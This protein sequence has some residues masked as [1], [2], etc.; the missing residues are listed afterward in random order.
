VCEK[1]ERQ[2]QLVQRGC[3]GRSRFAAP[4]RL[5]GEMETLGPIARPN[6]FDWLGGGFQE[7]WVDEIFCSSHEYQSTSVP[8][9][10]GFSKS[11]SL[12]LRETALAPPSLI[13]ALVLRCCAAANASYNATVTL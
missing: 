10:L 11:Y 13:L 3:E 1:Y 7:I 2:M 12:V 9:F 8:A 4:S 6:G 5:A